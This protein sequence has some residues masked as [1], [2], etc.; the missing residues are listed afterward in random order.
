MLVYIQIKSF[1]FNVNNM[2][3]I[4]IIL[5]KFFFFMLYRIISVQTNVSKEMSF[6]KT[7]Q[8]DQSNF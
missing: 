1:I 5:F 3:N 7:S 2:P 4:W 6:K 8:S